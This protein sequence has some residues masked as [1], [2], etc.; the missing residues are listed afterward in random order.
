MKLWRAVLANLGLVIFAALL[1]SAVACA[2][3]FCARSIRPGVQATQSGVEPHS[4]P[5]PL[6][7]DVR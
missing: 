4:S 7:S 6:E 2:V 5:S 3:N 1:V